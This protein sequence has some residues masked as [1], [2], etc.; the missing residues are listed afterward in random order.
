M[1]NGSW[2]DFMKY[3]CIYTY[4]QMSSPSKPSVA[5]D[6]KTLKWKTCLHCDVESQTNN[7]PIPLRNVNFYLDVT[8]Y[9]W[10]PFDIYFLQTRG[11][12][13][14]SRTQLNRNTFGLSLYL[15]FDFWDT[16]KFE[17]SD[18]LDFGDISF[19]VKTVTIESHSI[20]IKLSSTTPRKNL[21]VNVLQLYNVIWVQNSTV[22]FDCKICTLRVPNKTATLSPCKQK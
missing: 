13:V 14:M 1:V 3:I 10:L 21:R 16:K 7:T 18:L 20:T 12:N 22:A 6:C 5:S 4:I 11:L 9:R 19:P 15:I 2:L 17:F 8:L